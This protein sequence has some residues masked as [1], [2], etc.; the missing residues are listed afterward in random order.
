MSRNQP[1]TPAG[2]GSVADR[3]AGAQNVL[4]FA[5]TMASDDHL[6]ADLTTTDAD[7]VLGVAVADSATAWV[8]RLR[9]HATV[10]PE[11]V[12]VVDVGTSDPRVDVDWPGVTIDVTGI[13]SHGDLTGLGIAITN[14]LDARSDGSA[15]VCFD[16]VSVA[17]QH[18]DEE[19]LFRFCH[20]LA[21]K[22]RRAG[23]RAHY[24]ADPAVHDDRFQSMLAHLADAKVEVTA[25]GSVSVHR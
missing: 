13:G 7:H 4:V 19:R 10:V 15:A 12:G 11:T 6:C 3:L 18:A 16:S 5:P 25:D 23:A 22:V 1:S 24:H 8:E 9:D 14:W 2:E 17:S 20:T 21:G